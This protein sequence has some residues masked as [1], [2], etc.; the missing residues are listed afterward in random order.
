MNMIISLFLNKLFSS[1]KSA[2][3][4]DAL[5]ASKID[6]HDFLVLFILYYLIKL[7]LGR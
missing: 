2:L 3:T 1:V 6:K 7:H 5:S 4:P